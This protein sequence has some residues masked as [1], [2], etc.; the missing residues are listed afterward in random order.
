MQ[1]HYLPKTERL[2]IRLTSQQKEVIAQAAELQQT[3]LSD[4]ILRQAYDSASTLVAS[5]VH[6]ALPPEKW[7]AFCE[8][9][10]APPEFK[11]QLKKLM[12]EQSIFE[13]NES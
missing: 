3:N 8:A 9:L 11:P 6:F 7:K 4:F 10:D 5:Q 1:T 13:R 2:N 12:T